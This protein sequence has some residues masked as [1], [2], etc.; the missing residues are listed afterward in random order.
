MKH[1]RPAVWLLLSILAV[2]PIV[3]LSQ[4]GDCEAVVQTALE[5]TDRVC[6][7]TSRNQACYG[8]VH[9]EAEPQ[10][11]EE[12]FKF[13][14]VGD[15][16]DVSRIGS[17]RL[18]PMDED[19]QTWGVALMKVQ[20]DIPNSKPENVTILLF[21]DVQVDNAVPD[22]ILLDASV[23]GPGNANIRRQ[24]SNRAFVLASMAPDTVLTARGRSADGNWLYVDLPDDRGSGW[25][26]RSLMEIEGN[27]N[28]LRTTD[29]SLTSYGPMQAFYLQNGN[30]QSSCSQTPNDGI[31]IQTPEGVAEVR[32]WINEVKIRLGSTAFIQA[33][34]GSRQMVVKT[35]EGQ[36]VIEALG[37]EQTS[38]AGTSVTIQLNE[39]N[40]PS[41]PPSAPQAYQMNV[42]ENLPFEELE[43][44]ITAAPPLEITPTQTQLPTEA[45]TVGATDTLRPTYTLAPTETDLPTATWTGIPPTN[46]VPPPTATDV[47]PTN[48]DVP[49]TDTDVPPTDRPPTDTDV[50]PT[51]RPPTD[52]PP[53][54]VPPTDR[55]PTD[56]PPP[57]ASSDTPVAT[58]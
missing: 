36:A 38:P 19:Q 16:V 21:G 48:T 37:V 2:A 45:P 53:T 18:S 12:A 31:L 35:V 41:A 15:T 3:A 9:I 33:P 26:R 58:P 23:I 10:S 22:P 20:A 46:T 55:P 42:V 28:Q 44:E 8:H 6:T 11:L 13:E 51:D 32:L 14:D 4:T 27:A 29:P 17:L 49:P 34:A 39:D 5:A 30:D 24:P 57:P 40:K 47:L 56:A 25:V 52:V 1:L 54:D 7:D 43:R 50:P